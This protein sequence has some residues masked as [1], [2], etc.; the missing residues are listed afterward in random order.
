MVEMTEVYDITY[1]IALEWPVRN[2]SVIGN[3]TKTQSCCKAIT[4]RSVKISD[5]TSQSK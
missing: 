1:R 3:I 4:N 2:F 5:S